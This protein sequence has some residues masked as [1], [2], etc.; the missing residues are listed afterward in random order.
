MAMT[1]QVAVGNLTFP[2]IDPMGNKPLKPGC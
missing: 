1:Y 2:V